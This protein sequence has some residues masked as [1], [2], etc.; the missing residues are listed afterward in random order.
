MWLRFILFSLTL[1]F[2]PPI[3][4]AESEVSV[5]VEVDRAFATIGDRI[6]FRVTV[7]HRPGGAVL[8]LEAREVLGDFEIK[9]AT[10]FSSQENGKILEGKNYVITSYSL[11]EYVIQPFAV[12]Y[13]TGQGD[14]Q[15][16]KTNS[17]YITIQSVDQNKTAA[18][19]IR[20]VK[21]VHRI[22]GPA[23]FWTVPLGL[24][25]GAAV[26]W[27]Y[28][29]RK[30]RIA[31]K[32]SRESLLT[33][34]DEAYQALNRLRH[35]DLIRKGHMKLYFFQM[36]EILR[37]YFERRYE[38]RALQST[39]G[40]LMEQLPEVSMSENIQ[41]IHVVLSLCDLVKFAKYDPPPTE[42]IQQNTKAKLVIDRTKEETPA[43][44]PESVKI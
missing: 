44:R 43:V 26:F 22:K 6:N 17:L 3:A 30:K 5:K 40:E 21:G 28:Q 8:E 24:G 36:S 34:H 4:R 35:S 41:L 11:G 27:L 37:R 9:E 1:V 15:Q 20:G 2:V 13:R 19:D 31:N 42:I 16:I 10:D 23:W 7:A 38:I 25:L 32:G 12:Q 18:S 29:V 33:P 14:L 39:T